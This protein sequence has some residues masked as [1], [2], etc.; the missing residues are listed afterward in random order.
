MA[1]Y[2][3]FEELCRE[4]NVTRYQVAKAT[5]ISQTTLSTWKHR[6][7]QLGMD[8]L[9]K[10]A[11]YLGVS[12]AYLAGESDERNPEYGDEFA[13]FSGTKKALFSMVRNATEEEAEKMKK[14]LEIIGREE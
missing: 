1:V 11:K 5:G 7:S 12:V 3:R 9:L 10:I 6:N 13:D 14:I 4:L 2:E 8:K